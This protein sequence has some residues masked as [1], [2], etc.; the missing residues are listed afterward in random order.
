MRAQA[1]GGVEVELS[2]AATGAAHERGRAQQRST[3]SGG[4]G[5]RL[6]VALLT[7]LRAL[8]TVSVRL[9]LG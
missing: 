1:G 6:L 9:L 8:L 7:A 4:R 5:P 3:V 2:T